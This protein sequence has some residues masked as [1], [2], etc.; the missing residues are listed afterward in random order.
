MASSLALAMNLNGALHNAVRHASLIHDLGKIAIPNEILFKNG[1]LTLEEVKI[2]KLHPVTGADLIAS[3]NISTDIPYKDE[4]INAVRHHHERWDG[5]GYPSGLKGE[6]ISL[7]ARII[8][9][10]DT[11]D[12]ITSNRPYRKASSKTEAIKEIVSNVGTQF[13]PTVVNALVSSYWGKWFMCCSAIAIEDC[14]KYCLQTENIGLY[15]E[16]R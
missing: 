3:A 13:D 1:P 12:A 11:Y 4:V 8:S 14:S 9:V 7:V 2:V 15:K 6:N 10:A 5:E 16:M